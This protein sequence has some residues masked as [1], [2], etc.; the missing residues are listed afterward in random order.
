[1]ILNHTIFFIPKL[2]F[3]KTH[4]FPG[5][6]SGYGGYRNMFP[7]YLIRSNNIKIRFIFFCLNKKRPLFP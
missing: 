7:S 6:G 3:Y 2:I 4:F 1:M 5:W